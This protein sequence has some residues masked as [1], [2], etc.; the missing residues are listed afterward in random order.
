VPHLPGG[1]RW[2]RAGGRLYPP[3]GVWGE[4]PQGCSVSTLVRLQA[5]RKGSRLCSRLPRLLDSVVKFKSM[6]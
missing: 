2:G 6:L 1:C 4:V 5:K 3:E